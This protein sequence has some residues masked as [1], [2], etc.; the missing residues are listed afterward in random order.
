MKKINLA[1]WFSPI[2][3]NKNAYKG[4]FLQFCP[5]DTIT[6]FNW[7]EKTNKEAHAFEK[8]QHDLDKRQQKR[9]TRTKPWME[10]TPDTPTRDP[11]EK[12]G[13]NCTGN[14]L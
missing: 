14:F 11:E 4:T 8:E 6:R 1:D 9:Q 2:D 13:K 10:P 5:D 12:I 7:Y 3:R